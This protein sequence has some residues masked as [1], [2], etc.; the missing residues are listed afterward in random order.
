MSLSGLRRQLRRAG[1]WL[2]GRRPVR[3]ERPLR[4]G[5]PLF[6]AVWLVLAAL[7]GAPGTVVGAGCGA[8]ALYLLAE[9]F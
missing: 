9:A 2:F 3:Q 6:L 8:V 4:R 7:P 1:A 5:V